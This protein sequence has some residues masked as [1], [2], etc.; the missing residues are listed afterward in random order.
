MLKSGEKLQKLLMLLITWTVLLA[1]FVAY[2]QYFVKH[3]ESFF[4]E[5]GF[6]TLNRLSLELEHKFEEAQ[7]STESFVKL[8]KWGKKEDN[9]GNF[10]NVYLQDL[11]SNDKAIQSARQCW[12]NDPK[13]EQVPLESKQDRD[14]LTLSIYCFSRASPEDRDLPDRSATKLL[15]T[16]NLEARIRKG[17]HE[18][19]S[20]FE[21]V[22]VADSS[23][24]VALQESNAGPRIAD[25]K[26]IL[27]DNKDGDLS[28]KAKASS[29][30]AAQNDGP[31]EGTGARNPRPGGEGPAARS[32]HFPELD[33]LN[34]ASFF[35][36]VTIAGEPYKMFSQ[37]VQIS[38]GRNFPGVPPLKLVFAGLRHSSTF[39]SQTHALPYSIV[40][41]AGLIIVSLFS[42]SW[43]LFKLH[44]MSASER[45]TPKDGW[46]LIITIVLAITSVTLIL[47]NASYISQAQK[48]TDTHLRALAYG[49]KQNFMTEMLQQYAELQC[50]TGTAPKVDST[51][52]PNYL[53]SDQ[54]INHHGPLCDYPYFEIAAW[55]DNTGQ[56]ISKFDVRAASTPL[57]NFKDHDFFKDVLSESKAQAVSDYP[58]V[59]VEKQIEAL[60]QSKPS[61]F[62]A[63]FLEFQNNYLQVLKP[64]HFQPLFSPSTNE[65]SAVLSAAVPAQFQKNGRLKVAALSSRPMSLMNPILPPGYK[66]AVMDK[67]CK[68]LFHSDSARDG[69]ENFC[70]ESESAGELKP[71]LFS[72]ID[73][74]LD[75][76]Y[77]GQTERAYLTSLDLPGASSGEAFL[78]VFQEPDRQVTVNLAI[79]LVCS[80]LL[81]AYALVFLCAACI[82]LA[83]R[84]SLRWL[85]APNFIW[86][87]REQALKYMQLAA[88]VGTMLLLFWILYPL[89]YE[90]PLLLLSLAVPVLS[91]LFGVFKLC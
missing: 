11:Q 86:P 74:S 87:C 82:H 85:Y 23:G 27:T 38:L 63:H 57:I 8:V 43:P 49:M 25:L 20:D 60:R 29:G 83:I 3:Q 70:D 18:Q 13:H 17:L 68:V 42:L 39:A 75:I 65:F 7:A 64:T 24:H 2:Q 77:A 12:S 35:S 47:L 56:Q 4:R 9:A 26:S 48:E 40:I 79:I 73:S 46:F 44:Y 91:L 62:Q 53:D 51:P 52:I 37:P 81:G 50:L 5:R 80:I 16:L 15:Y 14:G 34:D 67:D 61:Y 33:K 36:D 21:N 32:T 10:L 55:M 71:W 54:A 89:L 31:K 59:T 76:S 84:K 90:A 88:A 78:I 66:F 28:P 6:R 22:L 1:G 69:R 41:W 72:G 30:E 19:Q 45:F 58:A